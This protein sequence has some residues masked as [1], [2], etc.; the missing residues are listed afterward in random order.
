MNQSYT[1]VKEQKPQSLTKWFVGY[2]SADSIPE[3]SP[4]FA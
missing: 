2:E 3:F 4:H 1:H